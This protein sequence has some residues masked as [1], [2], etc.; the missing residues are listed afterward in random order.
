MLLWREVAAAGLMSMQSGGGGG[1]RLGG[2]GELA[3]FSEVA[4]NW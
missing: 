1:G 3:Q 2:R 4:G